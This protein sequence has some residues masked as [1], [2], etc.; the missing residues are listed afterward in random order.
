M[1]CAGLAKIFMPNT[2]IRRPEYVEP[3]FQRA[4]ILPNLQQL[5][6]VE[7]DRDTILAD[8]FEWHDFSSNARKMRL[9]LARAFFKVTSLE[10]PRGAAFPIGSVALATLHSF[11]SLWGRQAV[12]LQTSR[13]HH[14]AY[15]VGSRSRSFFKPA[16]MKFTARSDIAL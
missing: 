2:A 11:G 13:P 14:L 15:R 1:N 12:L 3:L 9:E 6:V 7:K 4:G 8:C 5:G 10:L 16:A